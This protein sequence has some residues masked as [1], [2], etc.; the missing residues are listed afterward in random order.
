MFKAELL[1]YYR[2]GH[3]IFS[4]INFDLNYGTCMFIKGQNGSGKTTLLRLLAGLLPIQEGA[5]TYDGTSISNNHDLI[6]QHIDYIGHVNATKNQ[7]T[8]WDNLRFWNSLYEP[9]KRINLKTN[10]EDPM[11]INDI[12]NKPISFCSAGQIRRVALSRLTTSKK[13][14]WLL[15]EPTASLDKSAISNFGKMIEKHC[16]EGGAAI[17]ADHKKISMP[18]ID[19]I[20][21]EMKQSKS[22][23]R[24][25]DADPFF[26]GDW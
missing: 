6:A 13:K 10:F 17:I 15:D 9:D 18:M 1:S 19:S 20:S 11:L 16:L 5:V 14:L 21:I 24:G 3:Q 26:D 4:G 12:K 8:A 25:T 7:M 23:L 2:D 22:K